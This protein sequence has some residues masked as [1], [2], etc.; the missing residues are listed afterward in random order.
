MSTSTLNITKQ[1]SNTQ[2][3]ITATISSGGFLPLEIFVFENLGTNHLGT[4][5]GIVAAVDLPRIQIFTGTP[6]PAFGNKFIRYGV[7]TL[8][9]GQG[10]DPDKVIAVLKDSV[11]VL[12]TTLQAIPSSAQVY[13]IT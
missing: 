4:Y 8:Y 2:W 5:Q 1:L 3:V 7:G 6:I 10:A 12:S 9:V 13:T 11:Q